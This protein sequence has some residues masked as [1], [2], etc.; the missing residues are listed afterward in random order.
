MTIALLIKNLYSND[1]LHLKIYKSTI[2][3]PAAA[4]KTKQK[5]S[6]PPTGSR[7]RH[8]TKA[9]AFVRNKQACCP[10]FQ[11]GNSLHPQADA[12]GYLR[13]INTI[14]KKNPRGL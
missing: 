6:E 2:L 7:P 3:P 4:K 9:L 10:L 12:V 5:L 14:N 1:T 11:S 8:R 13:G